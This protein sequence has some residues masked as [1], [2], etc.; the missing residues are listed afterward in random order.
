MK[1]YTTSEDPV[2]VDVHQP[3]GARDGRAYVQ[4]ETPVGIVSF[5]DASAEQLEYAIRAAR[6]GALA[7]NM[8]TVKPHQMTQMCRAPG[9]GGTVCTRDRDHLGEHWIGGGQERWL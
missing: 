4:I 1:V 9:A 2:V 6:I 8:G 3:G 5:D 7:I